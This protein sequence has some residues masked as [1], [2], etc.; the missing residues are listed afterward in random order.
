M[1]ALV[2]ANTQIRCDPSG[3]Y[4]LNDLHQ[5]SG[6]ANRHR[7]SL[8]LDNKQTRDLVDE[9]S[10]EAGS[11]GAGNPAPMPPVESIQ[12][13]LGQGTYAIKELV[14]AYAMWISPRF[15]LHVIRA[16]DA[17]VQA[18]RVERPAGDAGTGATHR[19]DVL[20]G[21]A[22][23]FGALVRAARVMGMG[24]PQA[25]RAANEAT[26]RN[27]G[28]DL[29]VELGAEQMLENPAIAARPAHTDTVALFHQALQAGQLT[30][31]YRPCLARDAFYLYQHWCSQ[32]GHVPETLPRFVHRLR[33]EQGVRSER[34]RYSVNG[35]VFGP[36]GMLLW[37]DAFCRAPRELGESVLAF[38]QAMR[39]EVTHA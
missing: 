39:Q 19:A 3:R 13:G 20:V 4:C 12:R 31:P 34:R 35:A 38:Q 17:M 11:T 23:G 10:A 29:A 15:H 37:G 2:I 8:W 14:Y 33:V 26:V 32:Q 28:I 24:R 22:R 16:Y 9:L 18:A 7:P 5:A 30:A 27:T 21:A 36:A 1:N 6:G 25:L